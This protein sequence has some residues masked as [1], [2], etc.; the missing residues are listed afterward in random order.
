MRFSF[1]EPAHVPRG[2][3]LAVVGAVVGSSVPG[4]ADTGPSCPAFT[5]AHDPAQNP[6]R[7]PVICT[8]RC[9][10]ERR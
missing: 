8:G 5:D 10:G 1:G 2:L 6:G 9:A 4:D 7:S 3:A